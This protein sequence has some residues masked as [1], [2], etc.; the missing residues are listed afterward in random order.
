MHLPAHGESTC[1]KMQDCRFEAL[2]KIYFYDA[3]R[4]EPE[5]DREDSSLLLPPAPGMLQHGCYWRPEAGT[6]T[7]THLADA[8]SPANDTPAGSP[9]TE[10]LVDPSTGALPSLLPSPDSIDSEQDRPDRPV[11]VSRGKKLKAPP[12][13]LQSLQRCQLLQSPLLPVAMRHLCTKSAAST[14]RCK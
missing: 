14:H 1:K 7:S 8:Q 11:S 2:H 9:V 12:P 3:W 13:R 6:S 4:S 5:L 10:G